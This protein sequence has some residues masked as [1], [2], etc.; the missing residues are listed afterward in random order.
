MSKTE[1]NEEWAQRMFEEIDP[2]VDAAFAFDVAR[3][4][5]AFTQ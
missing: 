5:N 1:T 4:G 2:A 3:T